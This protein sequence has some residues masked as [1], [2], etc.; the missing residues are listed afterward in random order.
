VFLIPVAAGALV[1]VPVFGGPV[2]LHPM[3]AAMTLSSVSVGG[4][5]NSTLRGRWRKEKAPEAGGGRASCHRG[6]RRLTTTGVR[7]DSTLTEK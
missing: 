2:L 5:M 6:G 3:L 7:E 4:V 1:L